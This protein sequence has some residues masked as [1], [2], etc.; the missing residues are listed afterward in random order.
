MVHVEYSSWAVSW[1][2][3]QDISYKSQPQ[4]PNEVNLLNGI[5]QFSDPQSVVLGFTWKF[6]RTVNSWTLPRATEREA[7]GVDSVIHVLAR[8]PDGSDVVSSMRNTDLDY[9]SER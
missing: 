1:P 8:P 9:P 7:L 3:N 4:P 5:A 6:V 2:A